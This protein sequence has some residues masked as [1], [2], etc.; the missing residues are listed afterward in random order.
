MRRPTHGLT[1]VILAAG[2]FAVLPAP[3]GEI[4]EGYCKGRS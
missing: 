2:P 1:I 4:R 3:V